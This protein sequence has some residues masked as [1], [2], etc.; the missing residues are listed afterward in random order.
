MVRHGGRPE[1]VRRIQVRGVQAQRRR[2]PLSSPTTRSSAIC[3]DRAGIL[4]VGSFYRGLERFDPATETIHALPARS[5]PI[6]RSLSNDIV[7]AI[8]EDRSGRLWVG[9]GGGG[10]TFL[11]RA[12]GSFSHFRDDLATR[13]TAARRRAR[14]VRGQGGSDLDRDGRPRPDPLD[15]TTGRF[16]RFRHDPANPESLGHDD[17]RAI[18]AGRRRGAVDRNQRRRA[19]PARP[20]SAGDAVRHSRSAKTRSAWATITSWRSSWTATGT[21]GWEPTAAGSTGYTRDRRLPRGTGTTPNRP[22]DA[23]EQPRLLALSSTGP[24]SSGWAPT[25]T[26]SAGATSQEAVPHYRNDPERPQFA[27]PQHRLDLLRA[28]AG[29]LWVGTNDGGLN[30]IDSATR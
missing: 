18:V 8:L 26:A 2:T 19:E 12:T 25:A 14:A 7:W 16:T 3:E 15:P 20:A 21:C 30:R 17:V 29:I 11:D 24:G 13:P 28:P 6:P 23:G 4:W 27:Q 5:R 9:T 22:T 1:P 10:L